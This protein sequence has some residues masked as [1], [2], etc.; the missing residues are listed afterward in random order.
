DITKTA[1]ADHY[2]LSYNQQ[3]L[4]ILHQLQPDSPAFNM[5]GVIQ[6]EQKVE[7]KHVRRTVAYL[8]E[9]HE[10]FRTAFKIIDLQPRQ[11][12]RDTVET[13]MEYIDISHSTEPEKQEQLQK[14]QQK[15]MG[16]PFN[17]EKAPLLRILLLKTEEETYRL[18][19]NM[20]HIISDGW[21]LELLKQEFMQVYDA[22][23]RDRQ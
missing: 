10:S 13:P 14:L 7:E 8:V 12:I 5:P 19:F 15:I 23:S 22:Y 20:H 9:R 4:Y 16:E 3:R 21:S 6:L 11:F 1:T 18:I 2:P 17:L